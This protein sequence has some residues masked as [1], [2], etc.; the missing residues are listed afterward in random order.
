M[1]V[2][3]KRMNEMPEYLQED[4]MVGSDKRGDYGFV[5]GMQKKMG[6]VINVEYVSDNYK[7]L[8]DYI[9]EDGYMY[10]EEWVA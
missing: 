8:Y 7:P 6:R 9:D 4:S 2:T 5:I 3:V 10:R 1:K